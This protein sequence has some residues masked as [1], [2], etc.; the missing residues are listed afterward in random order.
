MRNI[1]NAATLVISF[2][3]INK[4]ILLNQSGLLGFLLWLSGLRT[5]HSV[6]E[7]VDLI[8]GYLNG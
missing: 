4:K 8:L 5:H 1:L 2:F 7:D 3:F 6:C